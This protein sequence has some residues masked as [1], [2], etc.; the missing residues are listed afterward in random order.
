MRSGSILTSQVGDTIVLR[1]AG[2]LDMAAAPRLRTTLSALF[3]QPGQHVLVDL[4]S[5]DFIDCAAIGALI[6]GRGLAE[7]GNAALLAVGAA[8]AV[9][10]VMETTGV[11][12][13]LGADLTLAEALDRVRDA[14]LPDDEYGDRPLEALLRVLHDLPA[15]A[16]QRPLLRE[17][18]LDLTL[19]FATR[20]ASRFRDRGQPRDDLEQVASVGLL[21]A[22]NRYNPELGDSFAAFAAPTII[23]ELRRHFR[24]KGWYMQVPRRLQ[25]LRL[26]VRTA[27]SELAQLLGRSPTVTD[28]ADRL[29]VT[30]ADVLAAL[31]ANAA[32]APRSLSEPLSNR[33]G[34]GLGELIGQLDPAMEAVDDADT[35]S[36]ALSQ[37]TE[38]EQ[39]ILILRFYGNRTQEEIAGE[40][41]VSQ[42]HVS[43]LLSRSLRTLRQHLEEPGST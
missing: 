4:S 40:I 37:L 17:V 43:R 12:K 41:G 34:V 15:G 35:V 27:Q 1:P 19:P 21:K 5:V 2:S 14:A 24:D 22:I 26:R 11:A 42:M 25:E 9:L 7:R 30:P 16:P 39:R 13:L 8:P 33:D 28:I 31:E 23:G 10:Q 36:R 20:L 18:V 3:H 32:Y 6:F 29:D 38:R